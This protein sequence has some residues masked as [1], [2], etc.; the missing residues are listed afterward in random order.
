MSE[1][2]GSPQWRVSLDEFLNALVPAGEWF[3]GTFAGVFGLGL[4]QSQHPDL[5][6]LFTTSLTAAVGGLFVRVGRIYGS[7]TLNGKPPTGS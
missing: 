4:L 3:V 1:P 7:N 6:T 2:Q 5:K